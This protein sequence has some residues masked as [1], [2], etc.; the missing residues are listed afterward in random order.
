MA[1]PF[2]SYIDVKKILMTGIDIGNNNSKYNDTDIIIGHNLTTNGTDVI[3]IGKNNTNSA[4]KSIIIG[5]DNTSNGVNSIII[6]HTSQAGTNSI[7][8]LGWSEGQNNISIGYSSS[9]IYDNVIS[10]GNKANA[11]TEDDNTNAI[12][13]GYNSF[14]KGKQ[15]IS[16][17]A[18]SRSALDNTISIGY[19]ADVQRNNGI[20]IGAGAEVYAVNGVQIGAGRNNRDNTIQFLERTL[21]G[22][23]RT[24]LVSAYLKNED[25]WNI[26]MPTDF[27]DPSDYY[28]TIDYGVYLCYCKKLQLMQNG[29]VTINNKCGISVIVLPSELNTACFQFYVNGLL[30]IGRYDYIS[31]GGS[32]NYR[33]QLVVYESGTEGAHSLYNT[34]TDIRLLKL[35]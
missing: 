8:L 31:I 16:I 3:N 13:I 10:I 17:G 20:A 12:G 6:G 1:I 2:K 30:Y 22:Y 14:S 32:G 33:Y 5:D 23:D 34:Q 15:S 4:A 19:K 9:A 21:L 18:E 27:N 11:L 26:K 24:K 35:F 7:S 29:E 25:Y 28:D